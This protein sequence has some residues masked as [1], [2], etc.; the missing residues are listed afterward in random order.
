[1][2]VTL[3]NSL[4]HQPLD[5]HYLHLFSWKNKTMF[6]GWFLVLISFPIT[7]AFRLSYTTS[8]SSLRTSSSSSSS[9][10]SKKD[11]FIINAFT[12]SDADDVNTPPSLSRILHSIRGLANGSDIRGTFVDHPR[13][14]SMTNVAHAIRSPT[15]LT[16]FAAYCLG[17]AFA[18]WI[19]Q[20][21]QA[22]SSSSNDTIRI[23]LG[24][25]P[26]PHGIRLADAVARGCA[27]VS[28]TN[29]KIE[30]V[31]TGIATTPSM[32]DFCCRTQLCDAAIMLTA[33][34]LPVD[35]NGMKFF[36]KQQGGLTKGDIQHLISLAQ[37][38]AAT[39]IATGVVPPS[40]G[41]EGVFCTKY[42]SLPTH[43]FLSFY[44]EN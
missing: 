34:H 23:C 41:K 40:S 2:V 18:T 39:W 21:Q 36:C 14:G 9:S 28:T 17:Y 33:S 35:R 6:L 8:H 44:T 43:P 7:W 42:V 25:D 22:S 31:Y 27:S 24:N 38:H 10:L 26:R 29:V 4:L 11:Q 15:Q 20:Q 3:A 30:V 37:Q 13:W 32:M 5:G 12:S 1:M 16:P 19:L